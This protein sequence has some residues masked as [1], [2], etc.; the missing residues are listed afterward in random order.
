VGPGKKAI[1][2][3]FAGHADRVPSPF[4]VHDVA[5]PGAPDHLAFRASYFQRRH[6][7]SFD[8]RAITPSGRAG[9]VIF[10][11]FLYDKIDAIRGMNHHRTQCPNDERPGSSA[12]WNSVPQQLALFGPTMPTRTRF[13]DMLT[14][15]SQCE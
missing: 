11:K 1:R 14:R 5:L 8:R 7:K 9:T 6:P 2:L 10:P 3:Q 15:N 4:L 13:Q 12:R